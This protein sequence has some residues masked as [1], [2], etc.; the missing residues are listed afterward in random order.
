M[1]KKLFNWFFNIQETQSKHALDYYQN[2][3][4]KPKPKRTQ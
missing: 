1:I 3:E 4:N 2:I